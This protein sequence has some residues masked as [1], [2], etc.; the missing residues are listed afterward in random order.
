MTRNT[1]HCLRRSRVAF[2]SYRTV[3]HRRLGASF[4]PYYVAIPTRE[5]PA[6]MSYT[7]HGWSKTMSIARSS[8]QRV[9]R[10]QVMI[11]VCRNGMR[12]MMK[13]QAVAVVNTTWCN[14]E[15]MITT[16]LMIESGTLS[17]YEKKYEKTALKFTIIWGK[18]CDDKEPLCV[19]FN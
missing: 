8:T 19:K 4:V 16:S 18:L 9:I 13:C 2:T 17:R 11:I 15:W 14:L 3:S 7:I 10:R 1:H 12:T 5:S 6:K